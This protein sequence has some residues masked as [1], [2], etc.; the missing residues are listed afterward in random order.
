MKTLK[1]K[2]KSILTRST[3]IAATALLALGG[4]AVNPSAITTVNA[5]VTNTSGTSLEALILQ[6]ASN[7]GLDT[8]GYLTADSYYHSKTIYSNS[9]TYEHTGLTNSNTESMWGG[10]CSGF[11]SWMYE[12]YL[13]NHGYTVDDLPGGYMTTDAWDS[14]CASSSNWGHYDNPSWDDVFDMPVGTILTWPSH[15]GIY[16]GRVNNVAMWNDGE[17]IVDAPIILN[18]MNRQTGVDLCFINGKAA[19]SGE[20]TNLGASPVHAWTRIQD[21]HVTLDLS[22]TSG[23]TAITN[24]NGCYSLEGAEYTVSKDDGT[25]FI[26]KTDAEGKVPTYTGTFPSGTTHKWSIRETKASPGYDLDPTVYEHTFSETDTDASIGKAWNV[27][28]VETPL[29]DPVTFTVNKISADH[30]VG[31]VKSLEGARYQIDY[32]GGQFSTEAEA[33]AADV[34]KKTWTIETKGT[35]TDTDKET[36]SQYQYSVAQISNK[37]TPEG[38][39]N[40]FF[41]SENGTVVEPLGTYICKEISAPD[42]YTQ[43]DASYE[44]VQDGKKLTVNNGTVILNIVSDKGK[45]VMT[46]G[47]ALDTENTN[48]Y[49]KDNNTTG[50]FSVQKEDITFGKTTSGDSEDFTTKLSIKN[51]SSESCNL[52]DADKNVIATANADDYFVTADGSRYIM[53]TDKNGYYASAE[54]ALPIGSYEIYEEVPPV[55]YTKRNDAIYSFSIV[56]NENGT[57][58][59]GTFTNTPV[60][61]GF[62]FAK[63]DIF[64]D[65]YAEGD[66]ALIATYTITNR[67][68]HAVDVNGTKEPGDV[69]MTVTTDEKGYYT[70]AVD[71]LPYGTYEITETVPPVGY[72]SRGTTSDTFVIREE[73]VIQKY[74]TQGRDMT[75]TIENEPFMGKF[76]LLKTHGGNQDNSSYFNEPEEGA[77]FVAVL[78]SKMLKDTAYGDSN[79]DGVISTKEMRSYVAHYGIDQAT[80]DIKDADGSKIL[81]KYEYSVLV[82]GKDGKAESS[83]LVYGSYTLCQTGTADPNYEMIENTS[84]FAVTTD[85]KDKVTAHY[86]ANNNLTDFF[87]KIVKKDADT[88]ETVILNS[89]SFK[90]TRIADYD[91]KAVNVP[92][93]YTTANRTYDTFKTVSI[94][95]QTGEHEALGVYFDKDDDQGAASLPLTLQAGTYRIEE[96]DTPAGFTSIAPQTVVLSAKLIAADPEFVDKDNVAGDTTHQTAPTPV[97]TYEV[98]NARAY[99]KLNIQKLIAEQTADLD[100]TPKDLSGVEFELRATQDIINP[101]DGTV[102][103]AKGELAKNIYGN[104]IGAFH[105]N[106]DG[107]YTVEKLALGTYELKEVAVPDGLTINDTPYGFVIQQDTDDM[108]KVAYEYDQD[109]IDKPTVVEFSKVK[110]TDSSE[111]PGATLQLFGEGEQI[112]EWVSTD[113]PYV[114]KGLKAGASYTLRETITPKDENGEDLGYARASEVVFTVSEDGSVDQVSMVDKFVTLTKEDENGKEVPGALITVTDK[115]G[116]TVDNWTSTTEAHKIKNLEV[117]QTYTITETSAPDGYYYAASTTFTVKDDGIDQA[118]K[119]I[120]N[121]IHY[122]IAKVDDNGNY[123]KGVTLKLT[124]TTTDTAVTLPTNGITTDEPFELDGKLIAGHKY[125]LEES[126]YVAGV[127][128][129]TSVEF[130]VAKTGTADITTITMKDLTTNIVIQK[131]DNHGNPVAGAKLQIL[132]TATDKDGN[133]VPAVD[134]DG[135]AIIVKEYTSTSD[136]A[137]ID[138]SKDVMGDKTYIL[139]ES[140]APFGF[141]LSKDVTFTVTGTKEKAQVIMMTDVRKTYYVSAVKVD[142]QDQTKL[143]PGAEITLFLKDGTVAKDING[144]ECKGKTDGQGAITWNV[145]YNGDLGGYYA[146]E[147]AAPLGYRINSNHYDVTLSENYD[148]A[149]DNA[150]KIVVNDEAAPIDEG[151]SPDTGDKTSPIVWG[152]ILIVSLGALL[153]V[154][155]YKNKSKN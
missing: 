7:C 43:D 146:Q 25:S 147:T 1:R 117:G 40:D 52:Y 134:K 121:V 116:N 101:D 61:G 112:A 98:K 96:V 136:A 78:T 84:S 152:S 79:K 80:E 86:Y 87:L 148:F 42:S 45:A 50:Q 3:K 53:T 27:N 137:G 104:E 92:V 62:T 113:R 37:Y 144:N 76:D 24:Y 13:P 12:V 122:Q 140:E 153:F 31:T 91:G 108:A 23:N 120:D 67:S 68:L 41:K 10:D 54:R 14:Y 58:H 100:L 110:A 119:L 150:V 38:M 46:S 56:Q 73:G 139:R 47:N 36:G 106:A 49:E 88:G 11:V 60:K 155:K 16:M 125:L 132:E 89:A 69:L 9:F 95:D 70:S 26:L 133:I 21:Y 55:G 39:T 142:A 51:T 22:K 74:D 151:S 77:T 15:V 59:D 97:V 4:V 107:T 99:G 128:K 149:K 123:V 154:I 129:A 5:Q 111:L 102:L 2:I 85:T 141:D 82:T 8:S 65:H 34:V 143:L 72:S 71:A 90:V 32:Y 44:A 126:E 63:N 83:N 81:S 94:N 124:D 18:A 64:T 131:A 29:N 138:I 57:R 30:P 48:Q 75:A 19:Y 33:K 6:A 103:T 109:V 115:D 114:I 105:V 130:E 145:E 118:E 127:Y 93:V 28:S 135:K 17:E 20:S 66:T 35:Y